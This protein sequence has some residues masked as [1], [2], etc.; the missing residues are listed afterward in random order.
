MKNLLLVLPV[1]IA[2]CATIEAPEVSST[3]RDYDPPGLA[4]AEPATELPTF[5]L[6]GTTVI[7][8]QEVVYLTEKQFTKLER[9]VEAAKANT[10]ALVLRTEAWNDAIH[11]RDFILEA[12]RQSEKQTEAYRELYVSSARSCSLIQYA[13]IGAAGL[14]LIA[15]AL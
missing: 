7:A 3:L 15:T 8:G 4:P 10:K 14:L 1:L 13:S 6:S 12:G 11:E 5:Q 9:F 2:G